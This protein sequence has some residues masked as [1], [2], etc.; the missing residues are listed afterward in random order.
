MKKYYNNRE[1]SWLQFNERVLEEAADKNVPLCERL[2]FAAIFQSNLDEFFM[3]RVGS[4]ND[5]MLLSPNI[6]ENKTNMTCKEQIEAIL[7]RVKELNIKRDKIYF[8]IMKELKKYA[9]I[10]NFSNLSTQDTQYLQKYFD[11]EIKPLLS[12]QI[13]GKRQP[14]PFLKNK[15]IYVVVSL[16]GKGNGEKLGIIPCNTGVFQRLIPLPSDKK[17]FLLA[18]DLI[19]YFVSQVFEHYTVKEKSLIR[20]VRNADINA[21]E[22]YNIDVD[23]RTAMGELIKKRKKLYPVKMDITHKLGEQTI[24]TLKKNLNLKDNR[25]FLITSP[26]DLSF[27]V[28]I[29][30]SLRNN[31]SLFFPKRIPQ[32]S[33]FIDEHKSMMEQI[34]GKD[35]LLSYPYESMKPFL[36]LLS[37]AAEDPNTV[38]IKMT[39]YRVAKYSKVI[40]ELIT[41]AENGKEVVVLVELRARFDEE[42]NIGWSRQLEDA[43]C[44]II[45]G[46][47]GIKVHSKLCL[48]TRKVGK[49]IEYITQIGTG[50]YNEKTAR[51]YTDLSLMTSSPDIAEDVGMVFNHLLMGEVVNETKCLLVAPKCMQNKII[52]MINNE[53][54]RAKSGEKAYIGIKVNSITD[55]KIIDKFVEASQAGVKID[56]IVRGICCIIPGVKGYTDNINVISIV[57]R[58]L[59]HSRIYIFGTE[60]RKTIYISSADFMTRNMLRRVEAA[61]PV[62]DE[63]IKERIS[64]MFE[65]MLRDNVKSRFQNS[66]AIYIKKTPESIP[67]NSQEYFYEQAYKNNNL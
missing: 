58:F 19:L 34:K 25:I 5:K 32:K 12:P 28:N 22:L 18:E 44:R 56:L 1:L 4:L 31:H 63:K 35:I 14:F 66:E 50:N 36:K 64:K 7:K 48:I 24:K 21:D 37:E 54:I 42:N 10:I 47:D 49:N 53:I 52:E 55:K 16:L 30:D 2:N 8:D 51:L 29:Q 23:Y 38:S 60:E 65:C 13:V 67:H 41:A 40:E 9:E 17:R 43:G 26:L 39:L 33:V 59:E 20:I 11:H 61:A 15:E 3:V 62:L 45:Y 57:G 27:S 6:K 46:L